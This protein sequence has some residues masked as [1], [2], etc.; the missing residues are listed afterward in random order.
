[1]TRSCL[2]V[3][4][5][6]A[7]SSATSREM[8]VASLTPSESFLALSRVRQAVVKNQ[9]T[10]QFPY[11]PRRGLHTNGDRDALLRKVV[12][13]RLCDETRTQKEDLL[14]RGAKGGLDGGNSGLNCGGHCDIERNWVDN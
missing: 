7:A 5:S 9:Y 3:S 14:G 2:A 13:A 6:R 12:Q 11:G 4:A 8:G 10:D 1:M